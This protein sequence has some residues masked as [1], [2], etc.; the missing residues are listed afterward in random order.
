LSEPPW[1][2]SKRSRLSRQTFTSSPERTVIGKK[3]PDS[4]NCSISFGLNENM[5]LL[6]DHHNSTT[7]LL[8]SG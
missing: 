8:F 6:I 2:A 4:S 5:D 3:Y 7:D 1:L